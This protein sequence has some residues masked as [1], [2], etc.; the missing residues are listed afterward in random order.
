MFWISILRGEKNP[1]H[2]KSIEL[3]LCIT[4]PLDNMHFLRSHAGPIWTIFY[5]V[6][7]NALTCIL[8]DVIYDIQ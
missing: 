5:I 6:Y 1:F 2:R 7:L 4:E 8:S 3:N